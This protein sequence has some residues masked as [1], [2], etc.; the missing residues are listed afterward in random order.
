MEGGGPERWQPTL[1]LCSYLMGK[2]GCERAG[3]GSAVC[4][5]RMCV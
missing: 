3:S 1:R 4:G 2:A 5:E